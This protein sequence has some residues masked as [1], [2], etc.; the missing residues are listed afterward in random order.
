MNAKW[1]VPLICVA[2]AFSGVWAIASPKLHM[3]DVITITL[4]NGK[5]YTGKIIVMHPAGIALAFD[6][7]HG[8]VYI[9]YPEMKPVDQKAFG[10]DPIKCAAYLRHVDEQIEAGNER[11]YGMQPDPDPDDW[12]TLRTITGQG[13][14]NTDQFSISSR[15]WRIIWETDPTTDFKDMCYFSASAESDDGAEPVDICT[16][17]ADGGGDR[18]EARGAGRWYLEVHSANCKWKIFVQQYAPGQGSPPH[19]EP[20]LPPPPTEHEDSNGLVIHDWVTP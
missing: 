20:T 12:Q 3:G 8:S 1:V 16:S 9:G 4:A 14:K 7:D 13:D 17:R 10:Y 2:L 15:R 19:T 5:T 6:D 18:S 11:A